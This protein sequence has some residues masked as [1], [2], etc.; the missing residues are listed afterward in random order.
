MK[1]YGHPLYFYILVSL[2]ALGVGFLWGQSYDRVREGSWGMMN[3][4]GMN[5]F[6]KSF[7]IPNTSS[8]STTRTT[9]NLTAASRGRRIG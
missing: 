9:S 1:K 3:S 8:T 4:F 5:N 7:N 6:M 2:V